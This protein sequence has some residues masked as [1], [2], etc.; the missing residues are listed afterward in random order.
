ML[1]LALIG[2]LHLSQRSPRYAHVLEVLDW[3]IQDARARGVTDFVL[4]GDLCEK[5]EPT[6][7]EYYELR[8]RIHAMAA[9]GGCSVVLG[10]HEHH[11]TLL[12]FDHDQNV[13]TAWNTARV[14]LRPDATLLLIPYARRGRPPFHELPEGG[15]I[16][17]SMKATADAIAGLVQRLVEQIQGKTPLIVCGHFSIEGMKVADSTFELHS[18]TEVVVPRAAFQG[19]ALTAVG[20]IHTP[21][22]VSADP[23]IIGVG[24]LT[25]CSF[26]EADDPKSYT[27]VTVD[28]VRV[29][30]ERIPVPARA[31]VVDRVTWPVSDV[32]PDLLEQWAG[33]EVKLTVEIP[34]DQVATFDPSVFDGIRARAALFT[35]E[36]R[37]I[38][39]E[40]VRAPEIGSTG[41]IEE[42]VST[43]LRATDQEVD[44]A[45]RARLLEKVAEVNS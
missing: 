43:W 13:F 21:Q 12:L 4:L 32:A 18:E 38:P 8:N 35:L 37:V 24:S 26:S 7:R 10:N 6:P 17:E 41:R 23:P 39:V 40:R 11:E 9:V 15:T 5:P 25:R 22:D 19:V 34:A 1:R 29:T 33:K 3:T 14:V 16:A 30:W 45:R 2:D 44:E 27:L 28:G 36:K 42:Q 20:H 31:M